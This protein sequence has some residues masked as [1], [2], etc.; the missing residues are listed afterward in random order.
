MKSYLTVEIKAIKR[1]CWLFSVTTATVTFSI[2]LDIQWMRNKRLSEEPVGASRAASAL[3]SRQSF[4]KQLFMTLQGKNQKVNAHFDAWQ[5]YWHLVDTNHRNLSSK[6]SVT[7]NKIIKGRIIHLFCS[8]LAEKWC[9]AWIFCLTEEKQ[10]DAERF[11]SA[12]L[13]RES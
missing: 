7:T 10:K 4:L 9:E 12:K 11:Y 1:H 2:V 13:S 3:G 5:F 6:L 8:V